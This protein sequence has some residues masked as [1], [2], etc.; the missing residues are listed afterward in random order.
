MEK[1]KNIEFLRIIGI[2]AIIMLHLF[3][4]RLPNLYPDI[5][6][7]NQLHTMT[8]NGQKAVDLFFIL[9]GFFFALKLNLQQSLWVF[10]KNKL[11]RFYPVM[12]FVVICSS[13][14]SF[15]LYNY[16][17]CLL[18]LT[19]TPLVL[20]AGGIAINPLWYL[21][22]LLWSLV[23]Y[24]YLLKNY[25]KKSVNLIIAIIAIFSYALIIQELNGGINSHT[26][27]INGFINIGM[28]RALGGIGIGYFIAEWYK[29]N[30][31]KI[32]NFSCNFLQK[33]LFSLIEFACLFFI[34]NNL[35][36]HKLKYPN[37]MIFI[38]IFIFTII[39]FLLKKGFISKILDNNL[40]P[41]ISKYTFSLYMTHVLGLEN[42]KKHLWKTHHEWVYAIPIENIVYTLLLVFIL[43]I[44]TYHFVEKPCA[45]YF[46]RIE[47]QKRTT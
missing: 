10:V 30:I 13:F 1:I 32:K 43:G 34:I 16:M 45:E 12:I 28:L 11:I 19:G 26:K 20:N 18:F 31:D 3:Q 36:L 15:K 2:V 17:M 6:I 8:C 41:I 27:I 38:I 33:L 39:L 14:L 22:S 40:C 4:K 23:L 9:S 25:K 24:F 42:V 21:S 37:Q 7:Y 5:E 46:K 35:I 47:K 44:F 29:L